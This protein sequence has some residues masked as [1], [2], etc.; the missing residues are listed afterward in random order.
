MYDLLWN[1]RM[2]GAMQAHACLTEEE[3]I[4]L[5]DWAHGRSIASTA[6]RNNMS[7]SKVDKIRHRLR[8]KYDSIQGYADLPPRKK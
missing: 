5:T 3:T 7:E 2:L 4:V 8:Q 1:S 6:M